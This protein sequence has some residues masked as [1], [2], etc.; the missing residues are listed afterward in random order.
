MKNDAN[1][2]DVDEND[3]DGDDVDADENL[4][5]GES[6]EEVHVAP[7]LEQ[8]GRKSRGNRYAEVINGL[9]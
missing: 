1:E 6:D 5:S 2:N 4:D 7:I 8:G 3:I 9:L